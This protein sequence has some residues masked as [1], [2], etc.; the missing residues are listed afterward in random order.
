MRHKTTLFLL[1]LKGKSKVVGLYGVI[2]FHQFLL[3]Q[4]VRYTVRQAM[5]I[6]FDLHK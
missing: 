5:L 6:Q 3:V 4:Y 2:K 1:V